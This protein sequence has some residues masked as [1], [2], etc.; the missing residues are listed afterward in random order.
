LELGLEL[1]LIMVRVRVR[2][3]GIVEVDLELLVRGYG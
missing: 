2:V 1:G 3:T